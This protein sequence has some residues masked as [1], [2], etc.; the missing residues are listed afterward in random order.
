[1]AIP[2]IERQAALSIGPTQGREPPFDRRDRIR[3][4]VSCGGT[5]G[6]SG[7]VEPDG[8]WVRGQGG[9]VLAPAPGRKMPPVAGIGAARIG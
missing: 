6:T 4:A 9:E 7:D 3:L 2:A 1:M 5:R 8:L